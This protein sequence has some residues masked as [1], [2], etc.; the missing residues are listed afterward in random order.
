[1]PTPANLTDTSSGDP[2]TLI[3]GGLWDAMDNS[4]ALEVYVP[5]GNRIKFLNYGT[6]QEPIKDQAT[7]S[8]RPELTIEPAMGFGGDLDQMTDTDLWRWRWDVTVAS[9]QQVLDY[10]GYQTLG[11]S[12]FPVYWAVYQTLMGCTQAIKALKLNNI[13]FIHAVRP[14]SIEVSRDDPRRLHGLKGW[15][16]TW[17]FYTDVHI[18]VIGNLAGLIP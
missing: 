8:D 16:G 7:D 2:F 4:A 6:R 17:P 15:C 14:G 13:F 1:M 10:V 11:A 3:L 5:Q 18:D 12:L 9:G